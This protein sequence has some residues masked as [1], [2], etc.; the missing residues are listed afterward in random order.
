MVDPLGGANEDPG[1]T[2]INVINI[3]GGSLGGA[4]AGDPGASIINAMKHR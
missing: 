4:G 2:T 1:A 3:D